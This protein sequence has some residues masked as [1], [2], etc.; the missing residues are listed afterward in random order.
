M[1]FDVSADAYAR[2]M[3]RYSAQL[4]EQFAD[5]AGVA[6]GQQALD[7]GCGPG[8]LTVV[9]A[10]RLGP[11]AVAAVDPSE[12]FVAAAQAR[13]PAVDIRH[14]A[15]E[16]L[17]FPD[18]T[19]DVT[20]AQLVVHFMTDPVAGIGEM[21]RVTRAGGTVAACVWDYGDDRGP[22]STLWRAARQVDPS[23]DDES[24]RPGVRDGHLVELFEQAGLHDAGQSFLTVRVSFTGTDAWWHPLTLGVGPAGAYVSSLD[25]DQQ[26]ALR[27][28]CSALLPD[29]PFEI[30]ASAWTASAR[31]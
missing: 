2:F 21:A 4:A 15:A 12:P 9:L 5:L 18:A 19:F 11:A 7:V 23:V 8:G 22:L 24:G 16:R 26:A 28:R 10:G 6:A 20:L 31:R 29:G 27:S 13:L 1:S 3:G 25:P 30:E 14:A 17:P